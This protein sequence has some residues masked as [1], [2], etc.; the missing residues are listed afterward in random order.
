MG[1][2]GESATFIGVEV[3]VVD[4]EGGG[5]N[6]SG[7][8]THNSRGVTEFEVNLNFVVLEG[9]EGKG[10]TGVAAEPELKGNED[11]AV[12]NIGVGGGVLNKRVGAVHHKLVTFP[13]TSGLGKFVPDVEPIGV[14]LVNTLT[15]DFDFDGLDEFVTS[16]LNGGTGGTELGLEVDAVDEITVSGDRACHL[17]AEVGETVEGLFDGFHREVSVSAVDNFEESNLRVTRQV[18]VLST[19][20]YEL[21]KSSSHL[22][23]LIYI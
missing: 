14:V 5:V 19:I 2:L 7:S 6:G 13:V 18:D 15:T 12:C 16:P 23:I 22:C 20:S 9:N 3:D 1:H 4:V 8:I 11:N 17:L 21:H 10:K